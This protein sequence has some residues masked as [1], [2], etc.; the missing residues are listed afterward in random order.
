MPVLHIL[1]EADQLV[2]VALAKALRREYPKHAVQV[3]PALAHAPFIS[4]AQAVFNAL[5]AHDR[6]HAIASRFSVA[7]SD[8]ESVA[9]VQKIVIEQLLA[10]APPLQGRVL[11]MGCGTGLLAQRIMQQTDAQVTG[12][13]IAQGMLD[14]ARANGVDAVYGDAESLPFEDAQFD[15]V[16]SSSVLQWCEA[17]RVLT[18]VQRVLKPGG[19]FVFSIFGEHTLCELKAAFAMLD[20]EQH[21]NTFA[22]LEDW[23]AWSSAWQSSAFTRHSL[24]PHYD[25]LMA[26]LHELKAMGA[27]HRN[28]PRSAGLKGRRYWQALDDAYAARTPEGHC[29]ATWDVIIGVLEKPA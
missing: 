23:Y 26:L 28:A 12:C 13:D 29:T 11:D 2:P 25:T 9:G 3:L 27:N 22:S 1:G 17:P 4:D 20:D 16:V 6:K 10:A 18:E 15:A 8:Y 21:I 19:V 24:R 5:H 14:L 7:S